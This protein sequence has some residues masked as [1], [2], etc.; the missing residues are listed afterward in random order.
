MRFSTAQYIA[1]MFALCLIV[2]FTPVVCV[3]LVILEFT[4]KKN[5]CSSMFP[6]SAVKHVRAGLY[7]GIKTL[8]KAAFRLTQIKC[9]DRQACLHANRRHYAILANAGW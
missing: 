4:K 3:S 2:V 1:H 5:G 8:L 9:G 7:S 6:S